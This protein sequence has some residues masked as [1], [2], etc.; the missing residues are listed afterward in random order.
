MGWWWIKSTLCANCSATSFNCAFKSYH[1]DDDD[2]D[3]HCQWGQHGEREG[4][5]DEDL[6][7]MK[8]CYD[9]EN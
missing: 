1:D 7:I 4:D 8:T 5:G 9:D 3:L 2:D 6:K